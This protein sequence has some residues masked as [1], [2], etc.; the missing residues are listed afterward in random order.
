MNS[1]HGYG[2][3]VVVRDRESLSHGEGEQLISYK[4]QMK[5]A[6]CL[7][8]NS[9]TVLYNLSKQAKNENYVFNK[10][11]RNLY[12][13]DFYHRAYA[14]IYANKGSAT[15]GIDGST[16][17]GFGDELIERIMEE[18]KDESY[19]PKPVRR[20]YIPKK[21]GNK[22][23]LG[24]PTFNDRII[25]EIV[26][27]ILEAI[28]EPNFSNNSHGF[29]PKRSCHTALAQIKNTFAGTKWFVEGDIKSYFD[30]I[31]H[32][33]MI[34]ILRERIKDE[35][36]IRL[37]WKFLRA[38]FIENWQYNKTFSGTPQGGIISPLLANIYLDKFDKWVEYNLIPEMNEGT[39]KTRKRNPEYR[40]LEFQVGKIK[41]R[42]DATDDK[43]LR[44]ELIDNYNEM[45]NTMLGMP[46]YDGMNEGY[47]SI[48]YVRYADD[49]LISVHGSKED[50]L[51]VKSKLKEYLK[52]EL[53][54][55]LSLEKTLI[56]Y[57]NDGAKFLNY[58]ISI[59]DDE[60]TK[61]VNGLT[62]RVRRGS[63]QLL[64]P[65]GTIEK[66]IIKHRMVRD[67]NAKKWK[68]L[69]RPALQGLSALE[70]VETYNAELR[71][72][73]NYYSL[74]ENVAVKMSQL[75]YVM[76]YSCLKTLAGKYKSTI[77]K[78]KNKYGQGKHWGI[79]YETKDGDKIAYFYNKGYAKKNTSTDTNVDTLYNQYNYRA[80]GELEQRLKADSCE[81][82]SNSG[83]EYKYE[84]H[85][86]NKLKNLKGKALWE[87]HM[88]ARKRKTLIVCQ[89]CHQDIHAGRL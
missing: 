73:Y 20:T 79:P 78:M 30:N 13:K 88:L 64:M 76:E 77:S 9:E 19:Q 87:T 22:R 83:E 2:V 72:I 41:K 15:K 33:V 39:A 49:F 81:L 82:C 5:G 89:K 27:M 71:G 47:V 18:I 28:Y 26:R 34:K 29:R 10:V 24:I 56:T 67:L 16:A 45:R 54:I 32:H 48:K 62:K 66:I 44:L 65:E 8:Q 17:D 21:D 7:M 6:E 3:P 1:L 50:A 55:E 86:I 59:R 40:A 57:A 63:V 4:T 60:T 51:T 68:T 14:N 69:H 61:K 58:S 11:Y 53:D 52:N 43:E 42:V 25:Q 37:I 35:K 70:I 23:P 74:A 38:G 12:N 84:V 75:H 36:M 80:S 31:N 85:H 46:Y